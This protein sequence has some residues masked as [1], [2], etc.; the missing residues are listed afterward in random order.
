M[1]LIGGVGFHDMPTD[2]IDVY[3]Q[4]QSGASIIM[5]NDL[6]DE[7]FI[8]VL[9]EGNLIQMRVKRKFA[10][11]ELTQLTKFAENL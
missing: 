7:D 3:G 11:C 8:G 6:K 9:Q 5:N 1:K 2:A 4:R 10:S